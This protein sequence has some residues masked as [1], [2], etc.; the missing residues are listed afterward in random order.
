MCLLISLPVNP[1]VCLAIYNTILPRSLHLRDSLRLSFKLSF[2]FSVYLCTC[3]STPS[4]CIP[5]WPFVCVPAIHLSVHL[6]LYLPSCKSI[7]LCACLSTYMPFVCLPISQS[8]YLLICVTRE[9]WL[10]GKV[11]YG[12][13]PCTNCLDRLFFYWTLVT[14]QA[15]LFRRSTVLSHP[16]QSVFPG[17]SV[18]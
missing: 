10:K 13:P 15:I 4:V 9:A 17:L 16:L 8:T 1:S 14:Q 12:W 5:I 7:S 11:R 6:S 18:N 2:N 3:I